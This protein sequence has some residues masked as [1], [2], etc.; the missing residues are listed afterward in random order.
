MPKVEATNILE[1]CGNSMSLVHWQLH[2]LQVNPTG[3]PW[4]SVPVCRW[5]KLR[6]YLDGVITILIGEQGASSLG[7]LLG[8]LK[9]KVV[10]DVVSFRIAPDALRAV[11]HN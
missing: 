1:C 9:V 4:I 7:D 11:R 3:G 5:K 2:Y 6:R 8:A 10:K